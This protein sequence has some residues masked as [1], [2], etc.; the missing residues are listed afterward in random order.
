MI[1]IPQIPYF[2][3]I[4]NL[5]IKDYKRMRHVIMRNGECTSKLYTLLEGVHKNVLPPFP[6]TTFLRLAGNDIWVLAFL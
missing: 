6:I 1:G 2:P 4:Y 3:R 5:N